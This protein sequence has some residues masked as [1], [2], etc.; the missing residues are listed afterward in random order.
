MTL[1][2]SL[3]SIFSTLLAM[4]LAPTLSRVFPR[5]VEITRQALEGEAFSSSSSSVVGPKSAQS[6]DLSASSGGTPAWVRLS[7]L[8]L[9]GVVPWSALNVACGIT[10]VSLRNCFLGAVVGTFPWTAVTC[11]VGDILHTIGV[12]STNSTLEG[13]LSDGLSKSATLS[14]VLASPQIVMELIFL[15]VLSL[16]PILGRKH[17][18]RFISSSGGAMTTP[19]PLPDD[20]E[21]QLEEK[22][23][24]SPSL[25]T[26][27]Q[28]SEKE[29]RRGRCRKVLHQEWTWKR[30]SMSV[31]RWSMLQQEREILTAEHLDR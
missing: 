26:D 2:T 6:N 9:V 10:G 1:L 21:E 12:V 19:K 13:D 27:G 31:P 8:R 24:L 25:R 14:S 23:G 16:A 4:P 30:I 20:E 17:L 22:E 11:Q 3:G 28:E 5:P 18:S 29:G 7:V 15:S